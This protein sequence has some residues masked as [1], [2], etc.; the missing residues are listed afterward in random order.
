MNVTFSNDDIHYLSLKEN[1]K[2]LKVFSR[3]QLVLEILFFIVMILYRA[4]F[5]VKGDDGH[6]FFF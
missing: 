4:V 2:A 6:N 5:Y 1:Y 3:K